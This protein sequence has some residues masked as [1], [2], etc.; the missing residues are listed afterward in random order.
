MA[1]ETGGGNPPK[2]S[3]PGQKG[4]KRVYNPPAQRPP[5]DNPE[6]FTS[7]EARM[8]RK[9]L[10]GTS[11]DPLLGGLE[12]AKIGGFYEGG[13]GRMKQYQDAAGQGTYTTPEMQQALARYRQYSD[14]YA[15]GGRTGDMQDVLNRYKSGLEGYT[16]AESQGFREQAQRGIDQ[17]MRSQL[18][19]LR[20]S[21]ARG[22]VRGAS[23]AAQQSNLDRM[24]MAEQQNLEQDLFV[25]NADEKQRRLQAYSDTLRGAEGE[26]YGRK[27]QTQNAYATA[28][29]GQ[30]GVNRESERYDMDRLMAERSGAMSSVLTAADLAQQERSERRKLD[31]WQQALRRNRSGPAL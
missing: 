9:A 25:R 8:A 24:R 21:Q 13:L 3:K 30:E 2:G 19:A 10:L 7:R 17:Q 26:E 27:M 4:K 12:L 15:Q 16:G 6:D 11:Q 14:Q 28:L 1:P 20:T 5:D 22:G 31:L 23:A 18:G 29:G